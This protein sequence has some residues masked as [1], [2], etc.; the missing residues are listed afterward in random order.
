VVEFTTKVFEVVL[1]ATLPEII[2][3]EVM[4][5]LPELCTLPPRNA[6][7]TVIVLAPNIPLTKA[8]PVVNEPFANVL[9]VTISFVRAFNRTLV[10]VTHPLNVSVAMLTLDT[11]FVILTL[12]Y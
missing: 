8:L 5:K 7:G 6:D 12:I 2:T 10:W 1:T 4:F 9:A 11:A 3:A